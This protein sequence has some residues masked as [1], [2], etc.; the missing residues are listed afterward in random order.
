MFHVVME[1]PFAP[2]DPLFIFLH[3]ALCPEK[4]TSM[5]GINNLPCSLASSSATEG[6]V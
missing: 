2:S 5:G 3:L 4:L 6:T 1:I